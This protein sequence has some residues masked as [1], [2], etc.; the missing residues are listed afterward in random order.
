MD[1]TSRIQIL[2]ETHRLIES[3]I[4]NLKENPNFDEVKMH[5][6]KKKK[7]IYK[8]EINRLNQIQQE[9]DHG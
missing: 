5:E 7:L 4:K 3:Q 2:K 8:D 9:H 1:N 6:L